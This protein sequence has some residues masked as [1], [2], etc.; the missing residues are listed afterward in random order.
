MKIRSGV[1]FLIFS[2]LSF[3]LFATPVAVIA[4]N[5]N[6]D[7]EIILVEDTELIRNFVNLYNSIEKS[8]VE[9]L[10]SAP[11]NQTFHLTSVIIGVGLASDLKIGPFGI[12]M[13]I[14]QRLSF[15]KKNQE[16]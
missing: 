11:A 7:E 16:N 4:R 14:S 9:Q 12:G 3:P 10:D 6:L 1:Y 8:A 5:G 2:I 15:S 13:G